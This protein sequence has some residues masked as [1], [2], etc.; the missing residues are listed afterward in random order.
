MLEVWRKQRRHK[1]RP[2]RLGVEKVIL[3]RQMRYVDM[4][5]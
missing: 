4:M 1:R 2:W 5:N 3:G